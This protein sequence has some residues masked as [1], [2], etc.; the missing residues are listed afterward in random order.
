MSKAIALNVLPGLLFC[1]CLAAACGPPQDQEKFDPRGTWRIDP[2]AT[3]ARA[4]AGTLGEEAELIAIAFLKEL[5]G[6]CQVRLLDDGEARVRIAFDFASLVVERN[7]LVKHPNQDGEARG[8]WAIVS[9]DPSVP[10]I[11]VRG[12]E[13]WEWELP[14]MIDG[15]NLVIPLSSVLPADVREEFGPAFDWVLTRTAN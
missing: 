7:S 5:H 13:E 12:T 11:R 2:S 8:T 10:R 14:L 1:A 3:I 6:E 15:D 4:A 9:T